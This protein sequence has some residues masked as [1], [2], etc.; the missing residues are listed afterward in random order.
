MRSSS[1]DAG[2]PFIWLP[3]EQGGSAWLGTLQFP[4]E[5]PVAPVSFPLLGRLSPT[6]LRPLLSLLLGSRQATDFSQAPHPRP[7]LG[8]LQ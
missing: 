2:T 3:A 4:K 1:G 7:K 8:V 5:H 6:T